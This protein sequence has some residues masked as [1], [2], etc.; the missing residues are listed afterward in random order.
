[1]KRIRRTSLD[2]L[3]G[4]MHTLVSDE[5]RELV[6]PKN[7]TSFLAQQEY[8]YRNK[9]LYLSIYTH[10]WVV[11]I[12]KKMVRD[13]CDINKIDYNFFDS[14]YGKYVHAPS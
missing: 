1:M 13:G 3:C 4:W 7:V 5:E 8:I 10:R 9:T 11:S 2:I 14:N 6:T 12:L